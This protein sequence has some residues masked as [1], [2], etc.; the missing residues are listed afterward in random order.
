MKILILK[1]VF[2]VIILN[3]E[4]PLGVQEDSLDIRKQLTIRKNKFTLLKIKTEAR[5]LGI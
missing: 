1:K 3:F 2:D 5:S 4:S